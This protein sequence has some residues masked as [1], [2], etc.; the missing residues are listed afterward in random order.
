MA[1]ECTVYGHGEGSKVNAANA[2]ES[3]LLASLI[4][5]DNGHLPSSGAVSSCRS[6]R[7][8]DLP[9]MPVHDQLQFALK[10]SCTRSQ[11]RCR[12]PIREAIQG[13]HDCPCSGQGQQTNKGTGRPKRYTDP[14]GWS[15]QET[16]SLSARNSGRRQPKKSVLFPT[17]TC[18]HL[19]H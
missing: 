1:T 3:C 13:A 8:G 6:A 7:Q 12:A 2:R 17:W 15:K 5:A 9:P 14:I 4:A 11:T 16:P 10:L 19:A 18:L